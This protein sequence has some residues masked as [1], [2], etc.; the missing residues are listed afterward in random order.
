MGY[1]IETKKMASDL[2]WRVFK[3][4]RGFIRLVQF[5][6]SIFAFATTCGFSSYTKFKVA[7]ISAG[8]Y[9]DGK[10][11]FSYPFGRGDIVMEPIC[12]ES[13]PN[14]Q[15]QSSPQFFVATGV[16]SFLYCIGICVM[17]VV[18]SRM[19]EENQLAAVADLIASGVL[20]SFWFAGSCA[21]TNGLV[22]IAAYTSPKFVFKHVLKDICVKDA[23]K[24]VFGGNF[25]GLNVS[26]I[27]GFANVLV[28]I[29]SL[30]FVYKETIWRKNNQ[31]A[32]MGSNNPPP[33]SAPGTDYTLPH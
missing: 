7:C 14:F 13:L 6:L 5:V 16:L 20:T 2:N 19:Y 22:D 25:A 11:T 26:V 10:I 17:Y 23:C 12:G 27:F 30:W 24:E 31:P 3:E 15:F 32:Q 29:G 33:M 28:W 18:A 9:T 21:W 4:P 1:P 8:N